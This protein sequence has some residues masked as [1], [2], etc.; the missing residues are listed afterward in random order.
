MAEEA[1]KKTRLERRAA[2]QDDL[3][4]NGGSQESWWVEGESHASLLLKELSFL[5]HHQVDKQQDS[6]SWASKG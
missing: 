5:T 3:V 6:A 4:S 2:P 1:P